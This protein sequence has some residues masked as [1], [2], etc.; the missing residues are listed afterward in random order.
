M[1]V[2]WEEIMKVETRV[3]GSA[4]TGMAIGAAIGVAI[5]IVILLAAAREDGGDSAGVGLGF[6]VV[7]IG[8]FTV[9]VGIIVGGSVGQ[10]PH[11]EPVYCA[12]HD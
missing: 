6:A 12:E 11:W 4:A 2:A 8:A 10:H 1:R 5:P 9:P 7:A 3:T